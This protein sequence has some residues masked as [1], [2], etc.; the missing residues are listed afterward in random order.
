MTF[1]ALIIPIL[2]HLISKSRGRLVQFPHLALIQSVKQKPT[3]NIRLIERLL[4]LLR[5]LLLSIAS[6]LLAGMVWSPQGNME[7][8]YVLVT[9]DW[10]NAASQPDKQALV[11]L[12]DAGTANNKAI[13]LGQ[14][15][16]ELTA[17]AIRNWQQDS[18]EHSPTNLWSQLK[19]ASRS[20][21]PKSN[22]HVFTTNRLSGFSG[23][24]TPIPHTIEWHILRLPS[25]SLDDFQQPPQKRTALVLYSDKFQTDMQYVNA[26]LSAMN[27]EPHIDLVINI[28][29][30]VDTV[31]EERSAEII[32]YLLDAPI[33]A[34]LIEQMDAG[35]RVIAWT[36]DVPEPGL[37]WQYKSQGLGDMVS[38][39]GRF[40]PI[41]NPQI[42]NL[43]FVVQL[44]QVVFADEIADWRNSVG[45][46]S[47]SQI[48]QLPEARSV[49]KERVFINQDWQRGLMVILILL[50]CVERLVSERLFKYGRLS[51]SVQ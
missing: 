38:L 2:I 48:S 17:E 8:S 34:W 44:A 10:L 13:L 9:S 15:G 12:I 6:L 16:R 22:F 7:K 33:P 47:E 4:L 11:E 35:T 24:K 23:T 20:V 18:I 19:L 14:S 3:S 29:K 49:V 25:M 50:F 27:A 31:V 39:A 42:A 30:L 46:L 1:L 41:D 43:G 5:I 26:A 36:D 37:N 40:H 32:F 51:R 21:D 28:E 45:R